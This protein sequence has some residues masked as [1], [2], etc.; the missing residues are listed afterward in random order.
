MDCILYVVHY[1][2][3]TG[4]I[5]GRLYFLISFAFFS[6]LPPLSDL[7][8]I[9]LFSVWVCFRLFVYFVFQIPHISEIIQYLTFSEIFYIKHA[10]LKVS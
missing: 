9:S 7:A 4:F 5:I 2:P 1:I 3:V 10:F 6:H 8:T